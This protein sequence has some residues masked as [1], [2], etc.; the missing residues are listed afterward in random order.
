MSALKL[1]GPGTDSGTFDFFTE[2][3][4]GRARRSRSDFTSSENDNVLVRGVQGERGA[5]DTSASPTTRRTRA[6]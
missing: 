3:I 4:N 6:G 1:Y 2:K 5:M